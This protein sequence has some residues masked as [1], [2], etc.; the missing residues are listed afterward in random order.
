MPSGRTTISR[1]FWPQCFKKLPLIRADLRQLPFQGRQQRCE[2]FLFLLVD[3]AV[4][5]GS[6]VVKALALGADVV[7]IGRMQAW[8]LAAAGSGAALA[9]LAYKCFEKE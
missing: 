4:Q 7:A 3:G 5:R 8:G 2:G 9:G 6:D 1:L